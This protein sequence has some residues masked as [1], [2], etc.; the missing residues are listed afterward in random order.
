MLV[1]RDTAMMRKGPKTSAVVYLLR[2]LRIVIYI[3]RTTRWLP[4]LL[5]AS[6]DYEP[7]QIV[8]Q[9]WFYM[10]VGVHTVS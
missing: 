8:K 4:V 9:Y 1:L 2:P 5:T 3:T 7:P 10:R 6:R